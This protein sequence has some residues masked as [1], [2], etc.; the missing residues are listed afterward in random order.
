M[1][2]RISFPLA[3]AITLGIA[4]WSACKKSDF[5]DVELGDHTAEFAFPLF[6]SDLL[7]KDLL[8]STLND[9][10][11]GDTV[12]VNADNTMTLFYSGD[13]AE[14]PA[15]D[16]FKF[17][18]N[19]LPIPLYDS[20]IINPI[21]APG[22]VTIRV[23]DILSGN[24]GFVLNNT[25]PDTL[26][27]YFEVP[28]M[29]LQGVSFKVSF[30]VPPN[31]TWNSGPLS[32]A[33]YHLESSNNTLTFKYFAYRPDG[34][35]VRIPMPGGF[36]V[37][38][39]T[40]GL[41][42]TYVEGY[43]GFQWYQLTRDTIE[44]D[45]NQTELKGDLKV[46]NPKVVMRISNSWGFPTRGQIKYLSF[47]GQQGEEIPLISTG[48]F[49]H[50]SF[51][52]KDFAYPSWALNEVGQTKYTD[53]TLDSSNSNI[54]DIFNS[55]PTRLIYEVD[56]ISNA[57]LDPNLIGFITDKS[58]I[59]LQLRVELLLEGSI[60]NFGAEQVLNLDF[61]EFG[62]LDSAD[63]EEVEFKLVTENGTPIS[64]DVQIYFRDASGQYIDSLFLGG[65][66]ELIRAAPIDANG[67]ASGITRTEE[68]I[69]MSAARFD[70][71]SKAKDAFLKTSFTTAN[72]GET[73][74]K[75]LATDKIVVKMGM[76]VKKRL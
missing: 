24:I 25:T 9:T 66:K 18:E 37:L 57:Q 4:L 64:S 73:F 27:G 16:I 17:L 12:F 59:K 61:G 38:A 63:V 21:S 20:V 69:P 6:T 31:V 22:G 10:L 29:S 51:D 58:T 47:I 30:V 67:V 75:L 70:N 49:E 15:S 62:S 45:I 74:V 7:L 46:K 5:Q 14:K 39:I 13:V 53:I 3:L 11:S 36:D 48:V 76:K 41:K 71:I 1:H 2:K 60:K 43:W 8:F 44:I 40:F 28:Q 35:R 32:L 65:P 42:F 72:G 19:P 52:Y 55:Q 23:A 54:A 34:V 56:G 50:D 26:S 68:F 33:G